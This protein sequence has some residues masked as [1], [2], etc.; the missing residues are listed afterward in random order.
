MKAAI[1]ERPGAS[2]T[3]GRV[4]LGFEEVRVEFERN[5][6]ERGEI[7]AAVAAYWCGQK[8]VDLWGGYRA[9]AG[10]A[11]WEEDTLVLVHSST[12]GLSAMT[13]DPREKA[14]RDAVHRA[15]KRLS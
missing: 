6:A 10:D 15:I 4:A 12:K 5:F 1:A 13:V 14:L 8:V 7:G 2:P 9:P 11:P 3:H